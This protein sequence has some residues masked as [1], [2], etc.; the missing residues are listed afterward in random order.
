MGS[1]AAAIAGLGRGPGFGPIHLQVWRARQ[2]RGLSVCSSSPSRCGACLLRSRSRK[3][4]D[5]GAAAL[6][7]WELRW[8]A[9][10]PGA[11]EL[12]G[13][14]VVRAAWYSAS[15]VLWQWR[16]GRLAV[17]RSLCRRCRG[18][19]RGN[20]RRG[21]GV[22]G[23]RGLLENLR[24]ADRAVVVGQRHGIRRPLCFG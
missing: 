24:S 20:P 5:A 10:E 1:L 14:T 4:L 22:C 9:G 16:G 18:L 13:A 8:L 23:R 12:V 19:P 6:E 15:S 17:A 21:V 7:R 3:S 2:P 11:Q